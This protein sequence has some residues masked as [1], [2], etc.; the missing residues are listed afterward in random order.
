MRKITDVEIIRYEPYTR[1]EEWGKTPIE[2]AFSKY[3]EN[4]KIE[5]IYGQMGYCV[6]KITCDDGVYGYGS[7]G[8]YSVC[9]EIIDRAFRPLLIGQ[10]PL[11]IEKL[12]DLMFSCSM[13]YGRRGAALF[14]ISAID[15]ALW[16]ILGKIAGLPV[17]QLLGGK[18]RDRIR[19]YGTGP[20]PEEHR[21][22]KYIGTKIPMPYGPEHEKEGLRANEARVRE[23]REIVGEDMEIMCDCWCGWDYMYTIKMA[24][25]LKQYNIKWIE[26]PLMPDD[27]EGYTRLRKVLNG[28]GIMLTT[29]EHEHTRWGAHELIDNGCVDILQVDVEYCGGVSELKKIMG[30]ASVRGVYV[31][32]HCP[33]VPGMHVVINSTASP[34]M[35]RITTGVEPMFKTDFVEKDG[36]VELSDTPGFGAELNPNF[37]KIRDD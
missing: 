17:Y 22:M 3:P 10:N 18:V 31:V 33:S 30:Y 8:N 5:R 4:G 37:A 27:I 15:I 6:I 14:A 32:P 20:Y 26:E 12:W 7:T 25:R 36:Y 11:E 35:E 1:T 21:K 34:F 16:D 29:G 9:G 24:E 23:V 28:M 2:H 13:P 19:C